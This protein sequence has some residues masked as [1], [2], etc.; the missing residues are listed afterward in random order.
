MPKR[1]NPPAQLKQPETH[2]PFKLRSLEQILMLFNNGEFLTEVMEGHADLMR[3]LT[4]HNQIYGSKGCQGSMTLT[5][6]Y[7]VG[8]AGDAG[9]GAKVSF[10]AP[11]KP[12]SSAAAYIDG[13]GNLTLYSPMMAR[14]HGGVRDATPAFD[15]ETGEIRDI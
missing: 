8:N 11:K 3:D 4:E 2:D 14:M 1:I 10:T 7:A 6:S 5:I 13:D 12:Q 15:P 9:M